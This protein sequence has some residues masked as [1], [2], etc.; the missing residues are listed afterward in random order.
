MKI[1]FH[2]KAK[3]VFLQIVI[4]GGKKNNNE[5]KEWWAPKMSMFRYTW[6][7]ITGRL[8]FNFILKL[9]VYPIKGISPASVAVQTWLGKM[10]RKYVAFKSPCCFCLVAKSCLT[11]LDPI[12][13][14]MPGPSVLHYLVEFAQTH[15]H[16]VSDAIQPSHPLSPPSPPALNLSQL[17]GLLQ[18]VGFL[19]QVAKVLL[20]DP[21][22]PFLFLL[23]GMSL[24]E[25]MKKK[26]G[27]P[28]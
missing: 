14:S 8:F 6:E 26:Q 20:G 7:I 16:Q 9:V 4:A 15:V 2:L 3:C 5:K 27:L 18:W 23:K 24:F 22:S 19:S 11:L 25:A 12:V 13:C 1:E 28:D 17:Q 10:F 21:T